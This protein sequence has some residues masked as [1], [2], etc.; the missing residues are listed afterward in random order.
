MIF[1]A[2][3]TKQGVKAPIWFACGVC[4]VLF[5]S[6]QQEFVITSLRDYAVGRVKNSLHPSG[7]AVD[8]KATHLTLTQQQYI[9]R[10]LKKIL[11][12]FGFDVI[13]HGAPLHFH[14]EFDP[15]PAEY[16]PWSGI[17]VA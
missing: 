15:K 6:I 5:A 9:L 17:I 4:T 1:K 13:L 14:I 3:V 2:F 7:R 16:N 8:V 11:D 12:P 10:E